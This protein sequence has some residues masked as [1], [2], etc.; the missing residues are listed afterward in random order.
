MK[1]NNSSSKGRGRGG[2]EVG[3]GTFKGKG[4]RRGG[5]KG[6]IHNAGPII[7]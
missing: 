7:A 5:G 2:W 6:D 3:R 1:G 4:R